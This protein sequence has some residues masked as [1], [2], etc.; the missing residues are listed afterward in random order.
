MHRLSLATGWCGTGCHSRWGW[1][2]GA[3]RGGAEMWC[4]SGNATTR[5]G[6]G[7]NS[8]S[9]G[10][11]GR[12]KRAARGRGVGYVRSPRGFHRS[13]RGGNVRSG[14]S[15]FEVA[16]TTEMRREIGQVD[17]T[18]FIVSISVYILASISNRCHLY[19]SRIEATQTKRDN[20][21]KDGKKGR[22]LVDCQI[23]C[24]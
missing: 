5:G 6:R 10:E 24:H 17:L 12:R 19:Y 2:V 20:W 16:I 18:H 4:P 7:G 22:A 13:A 15:S 14:C 11:S 23:T 21:P 3:T 8:L 9:G 1:G